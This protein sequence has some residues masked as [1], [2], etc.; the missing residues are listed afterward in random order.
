MYICIYY[1]I[2]IFV[3]YYD[4]RL[5]LSVS[6]VRPVANKR[7][8]ECSISKDGQPEAAHKPIKLHKITKGKILEFKKE[9]C[10]FRCV[11]V[12]LLRLSR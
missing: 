11:L 1:I 8:T 10:G 2:S 9:N 4:R 3:Y 7:H 12:F 6:V 5:Y